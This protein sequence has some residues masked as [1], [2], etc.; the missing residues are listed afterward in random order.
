MKFLSTE[1]VPRQQRLQLL[2][3]FVG[4][5]VARRQF[6]PLIDEISIEMCTLAMSDDMLLAKARYSPIIGK[7]T[8]EM[9]ADGCDSYLLTVH[10]ADCEIVIE[11][12]APITV[13]K[14]D[15]MLVNEATRSEFRLPHIRVTVLSLGLRGLMTRLPRLE[16]QPYYHVPGD[17]QGIGLL[18][19]YSDLLLSDPRTAKMLGSRAA[20][21]LYDLAALAVGA[22]TSDEADA[23]RSSIGR[24]RLELAKREIVRRRREPDLKVTSIAREQGVTPRYLQRLFE[25]EGSSFSEFLRDSRLDL[26]FDM[27]KDG[28]HDHA[29]ISTVAYECGFSDLSHFNRSF[30]KRFERTP[31]DVRA[32]ALKQ[33]HRP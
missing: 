18:S 13:R 9:L 29:G 3:D 30:R 16:A 27:L 11:G 14:G 12:G 15:V 4:R 8:A 5:Q 23:D 21:H 31:S 26:A 19:G 20:S 32:T 1:Q 2:H 24:A 6:E 17:A 22:S 33:R 10:D 25:A 28:S 7:R